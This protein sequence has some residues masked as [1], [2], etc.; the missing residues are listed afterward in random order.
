MRAGQKLRAELYDR[1]MLTH[2]STGVLATVDNQIDQTTGTVRLR[3]TFDNRDSRLFPNEFV[4][5]RL[6]LQEKKNVVLLDT[7]AI[8]RSSSQTYVYLVKEDSTVTVRQIQTGVTEGDNTEITSG[9]NGGETIVM[10][11]VDKLQEGS[12]VNVQFPGESGKN[13]AGKSGS[14]K[15]G[16]GKGG[17]KPK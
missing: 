1:D 8:Q 17:G 16:A 14:N 15:T 3:A 11:G 4:N 9:L 2:L 5:V 13:S 12:P 7:A 6:L 10:T